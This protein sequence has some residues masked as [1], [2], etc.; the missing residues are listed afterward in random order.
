MIWISFGCEFD[1]CFDLFRFLACI[2]NESEFKSLWVGKKISSKY[3]QT[4]QM[5]MFQS[6]L[7]K[8]SNS[9]AKKKSH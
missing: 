7:R 8:E 5:V 3:S 6:K 9:Y 1:F 4:K 2:E